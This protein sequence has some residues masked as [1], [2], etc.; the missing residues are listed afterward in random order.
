VRDS[1]EKNSEA[2]V[3]ETKKKGRER[4]QVMTRQERKENRRDGR[5][6]QMLKLFIRTG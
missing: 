2:I 1:E 3:E 6:T 4:R 5:T